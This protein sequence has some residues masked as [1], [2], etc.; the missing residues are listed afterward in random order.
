VKYPPK[1]GIAECDGDRSA[2]VGGDIYTGIGRELKLIERYAGAE[3]DRIGEGQ[4]GILGCQ[5]RAVRESLEI[6]SDGSSHEREVCGEKKQD[7]IVPIFQAVRS[8][9]DLR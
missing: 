3:D 9:R 2:I 7:G 4:A 8:L 5:D 1:L 6:K